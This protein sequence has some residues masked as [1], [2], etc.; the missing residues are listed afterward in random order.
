MRQESQPSRPLAISE[1]LVAASSNVSSPLHRGQTSSSRSR[2][3]IA[4]IASSN[5]APLGR[6]RPPEGPDEPD[7]KCQVHGQEV[8]RN[9]HVTHPAE[10]LAEQEA[11]QPERVEGELDDEERAIEGRRHERAAGGEHSTQEEGQEPSKQLVREKRERGQ[12]VEPGREDLADG[13]K[14]SGRDAYATRELPAHRGGRE[15]DR[16]RL[17][18]VPDSEASPPRGEG[19]QQVLHKGVGL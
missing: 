16:R 5:S 1:P 3:L 18:V 14:A 4:R 15:V 17:G 9:H 12:W 13:P 7:E 8:V 11:G 2:G 6:L 10:A 19:Y